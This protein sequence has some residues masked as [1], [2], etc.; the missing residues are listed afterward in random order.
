MHISSFLTSHS[1]KRKKKCI[2]FLFVLVVVSFSSVILWSRILSY[3]SSSGLSV[4]RRYSLEQSSKSSPQQ[5]EVITNLFLED[6]VDMFFSSFNKYIVS[7]LASHLATL[8]YQLANGGYTHKILLPRL[9][10]CK[11]MIQ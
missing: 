1:F 9:F 4:S 5:P 11:N 10:S 6:L 7:L 3:L 2:L 8:S